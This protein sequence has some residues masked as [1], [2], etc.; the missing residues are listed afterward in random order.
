M[1]YD[2]H[3]AHCI[4]YKASINYEFLLKTLHI[5]RTFG[6]NP[7]YD[8]VL[9]IHKHFNQCQMCE[10]MIPN[11]YLLRGKCVFCMDDDFYMH[12]Q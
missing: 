1:I 4:Q 10:I 11:R 7:S 9:L 5:V 12:E 2:I 3:V 8:L 6:R